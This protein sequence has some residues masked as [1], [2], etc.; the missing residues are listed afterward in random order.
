MTAELPLSSQL[1]KS[2]TN[3]KALFVAAFL[4]DIGKGRKEDH[5]DRRARAS[6]ASCVRVWA[7]RRRKPISS[8]GSSKSI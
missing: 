3:R 6:R 4:H 7:S 1:I 2:I 8:R 5:S